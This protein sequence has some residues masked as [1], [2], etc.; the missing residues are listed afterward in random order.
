MDEDEGRG[1][2]EKGPERGEDGP[3]DNGRRVAV[4]V[5]VEV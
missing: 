1:R 4:G 3:R 2:G 5:A